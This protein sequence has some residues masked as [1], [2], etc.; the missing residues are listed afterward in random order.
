MGQTSIRR[1]RARLFVADCFPVVIEGLASVAARIGLVVAGH[2]TNY[3]AA[4]AAFRSGGF[5]I[6]MIDAD[7]CGVGSLVAELRSLAPGIP[8]V[9]TAARADHPALAEA[10]AAGV[11]GVIIKTGG[12]EALGDCIDAVLAGKR[13]IDRDALAPRTGKPGAHDL[14][15]T[16]RE[17]DVARLV[18]RGQRNRRI[19]DALGIT[20]GTVKMHLHNVYNKLG[21]ESRTQ[22][23][24]DVR[25]AGI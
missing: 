1:A 22:L 17:W 14:P 19:A 7:I 12:L 9:I 2:A 21:L 5:D 11:E 16:P 15:L 6:A 18:A 3:D 23:A 4:K 13:C 24:T 25:L 10:I 8:V 20:E